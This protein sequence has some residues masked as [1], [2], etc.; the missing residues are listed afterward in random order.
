[1]T[2]VRPL[3]QLRT[4]SV[5][6]Q[7]PPLEGL[8]AFAEDLALCEA[9]TREGGAWAAAT[10]HTL[11]Q[12]VFDPAWVERADLA[13]RLGPE[14]RRFDRFGQRVDTVTFHPAWHDILGLAVTYGVH[15]LPWTSHR[16]GAHVAR[17]A[18]EMLFAQLECGALCPVD[19]TY[20]IVPMLRR[21]PELAGGWEAKMLS[22][23]Y[24]PRAIPHSEKT[25]ITLAFTSTEKQG[26]SDIRRNTTSA[27][28][29]ACAGPGEE[30][31]LRGHKWFCSSAGADVIFV[32]A[33]TE[34]GPG[35]F[36][37]PRWLPDGTRN[38]ISIERLKTKLGNRSNASAELEFDGAHGWLVGEEG[39]GIPTVM[40]FM[41]H[42]RFGCAL[43]PAG[44]MRQALSQ[45]MHHACH[46]VAFQ[47]RLIDHPLMR[48]VLADLAIESEAATQLVMRVGRAFDEAEHDPMSRGF[49]R[50]TVAVAKYWINKRLVPFVHEALETLG[51]AGYIEESI[52]PRLY[53]EA[54]LNGIWE[55]PGNVISLDILRAL[56]KDAHAGEA[57]FIELDTVRGA[58]R[59]LDAAIEE[60]RALVRADHMPEVRARYLA[61]R[62]A[63]VMQATQL[64]R[65]APNFV[66]DAFCLTRVAGVGG[67]TFGTLPEGVDIDA[68]IRRAWPAAA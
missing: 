37:V 25:G 45:A 68:I 66:A 57:F 6:N 21:Q 36:L 62:M 53:R 31:L 43:I 15:A 65:H 22:N 4:H 35:C 12:H 17:G 50:I 23:S 26:G 47:R 9:V 41:L 61:E 39:R 32:V 1:M 19:I 59:R 42:T 27:Q 63:I 48:N 52:M 2:D 38:P 40:E 3:Q 20:G 51:G 44:L 67:R 34:K 24:D 11:G 49:G 7:P 46:R 64:V 14:L 55:G 10:L 5:E 18:A 60:V 33:Q 54:P 28:P 58:D 29:A 8:D 30:Y 13:N 56:R 16:R